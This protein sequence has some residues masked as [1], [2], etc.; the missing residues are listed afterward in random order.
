MSNVLGGDNLNQFRIDRWRREHSTELLRW[1]LAEVVGSLRSLNYVLL[2][3]EDDAGTMLP[4]GLTIRDCLSRTDRIIIQRVFL[5]S[6][7]RS[8]ISCLE[9][10]VSSRRISANLRDRISGTVL[11]N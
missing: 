5:H 10:P 3:G 4:P 6:T 11:S 8:M 2:H 9:R 1:L 7:I